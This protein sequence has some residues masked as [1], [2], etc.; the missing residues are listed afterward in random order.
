MR[1]LCMVRSDNHL[2]TSDILFVTFHVSPLTIHVPK[3]VHA[4]EELMKIHP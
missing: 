3:N 1:D 4:D 2:P